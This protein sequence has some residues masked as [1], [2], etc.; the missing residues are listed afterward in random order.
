MEQ[1]FN[2]DIHLQEM[3]L[4]TETEETLFILY[5]SR[6]GNA[7]SVAKLANDY[8]KYCGLKSVLLDM[9]E[10]DYNSFNKIK[11]LIIVVSTHGE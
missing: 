8:A 6:Y 10:L 5:G 2:H 11:H 1:S 9:P 7:K 4:L 3:D